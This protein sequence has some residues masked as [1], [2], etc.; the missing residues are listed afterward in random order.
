MV[1]S[2]RV[3]NVEILSLLDVGDWNI[4][5]LFP[6]VAPDVWETYRE[7]YPD[8][9]RAGTG[10]QTTATC[11][12]VRSADS[13][14]LVDTGLGPGPH[15]NQGGQMGQL[16]AELES[17]GIKPSDVDMV[18][19]THL[20]RDHVGWNA[21]GAEGEPIPTFPRARYLLPKK[22]WEYFSQPELRE[23]TAHLRGTM[24]LYDKGL[25]E[26]VDGEQAVSPVLTL[27]P[28]PG[29]TPGH[30]AVLVASD[31]E[32]AAIVGDLAHAPPQVHEVDWSSH[33]D[34]D[35]ELCTESR[36]R[37]FGDVESQHALLCAGHFPHPGFGHLVRLNGR[38]IFQALS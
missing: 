32:R 16:M 17:V 15:A 27:F 7:L 35:P 11:Y 19:I 1:H 18:L 5:N 8:A 2:A 12:A 33:Y 25:I 37:L 20:H 14:V 38:R 26:L 28:T 29:H 24:S 21:V 9:L 22:D 6:F 13:T 36:G 31:G 23:R 34:F 4:D 3:G 10:I 30:Q